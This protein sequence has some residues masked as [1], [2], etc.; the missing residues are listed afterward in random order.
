MLDVSAIDAGK[1]TVSPAPA[2]L[3]AIVRTVYERFREQLDAAG[4]HVAL[5]LAPELPGRWDPARIEQVVENLI[6][7]SVKYA[8]GAALALTTRGSE[9]GAQ[10]VVA[11][12]G[13]GVAA[14][15]REAIFERFERV[16]SPHSVGG[17]GLGLFIVRQL[18]EAHGGRVRVED[19]SGGGATF[20]IDLPAR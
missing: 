2:D 11:D 8:P 7:N 13:P 16:G 17:L 15:M 6:G 12:R 4:S 20:V 14:D 10:L 5:E 1:L 3:S 18:V 9:G 19:T